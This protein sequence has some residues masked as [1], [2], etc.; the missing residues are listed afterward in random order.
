MLNPVTISDV[1]AKKLELVSTIKRALEE[2]TN[3]TGIPIE[4][5][6]FHCKDLNAGE[7]GAVGGP[8]NYLYSCNIRIFI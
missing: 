6:N 1:Q 4:A 2:F 8:L 7:I 5:I 3:S